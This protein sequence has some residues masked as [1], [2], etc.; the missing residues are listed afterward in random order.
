MAIFEKFLY[1]F[2]TFSLC[3]ILHKT[4]DNNSSVRK[5]NP[6]GSRPRSASH[7][8][9]YR[10]AVP[11]WFLQKTGFPINIW[12]WNFKD[13][14]TIWN[15]IEDEMRCNVMRLMIKLIM[16]K[17]F[18]LRYANMISFLL[19][20]QYIEWYCKDYVFWQLKYLSCQYFNKNNFM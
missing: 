19:S 12:L 4:Y 1:F 5:G 17:Q 11:L 15:R 3:A 16:C 10:K 8:P 9:C 7:C 13:E 18:Y 6:W 14:W 2:A 20:L